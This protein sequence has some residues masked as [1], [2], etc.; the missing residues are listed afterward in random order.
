MIYPTNIVGGLTKL[1]VRLNILIKALNNLYL[2]TIYKKYNVV[3]PFINNIK[4]NKTLNYLYNNWKSKFEI[5]YKDIA[6]IFYDIKKEPNLSKKQ[7]RLSEIKLYCMRQEHLKLLNDSLLLII[8][9][10]INN[11]NEYQYGIILF[12]EKKK[13]VIYY[14][15]ET[16]VK[17]IR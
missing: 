11:K 15:L 10:K 13:N 14:I 6:T 3:N 4:N 2:D 1:N 9:N 5:D 17:V 8:E 12:L 7:D 16:L